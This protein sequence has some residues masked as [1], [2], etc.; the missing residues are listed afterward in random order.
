MS[1]RD[2][3][4]EVVAAW[5][6]DPT[7]PEAW[8][9]WDTRWH[10]AIEALRRALSEDAAPAAI[11]ER[12]AAWVR[13]CFGE[14]AMARTER[15]ARLMEEAVELAQAEGVT[16][17][18]ARGIVERAYARPT[19]DPAQE[20]GGV[21]MCLAAWS[22]A[23]GVDVAA[24]TERE[25]SRVEALPVEHFKARHAAKVAAGSAAPA[26]RGEQ[27]APERECVCG[28]A[29]SAHAVLSGYAGARHPT[30]LILGGPSG[31]CRCEGFQPRKCWC[32]RDSTYES[33]WCGVL[34]PKPASPAPRAPAPA[35]EA[36][37][38]ILYALRMI[39]CGGPGH[40]TRADPDC[41]T[42]RG[43]SRIETLANAL[44]PAPRAPGDDTP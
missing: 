9:A 33:G 10:D 39:R 20:A 38:E 5:N 23:S 3:A 15:A 27:P 14:H 31:G 29:E 12:A 7:D 35:E 18:L 2:R 43:L 34:H 40:Q 13:R 17:A 24:E 6:W 1:L 21:G 19:G 36:A 44:L 8:N 22:V 25:V 37:N 28:H 42:C 11:G 16:V 26:P 4:A 41:P 30:C 32:G